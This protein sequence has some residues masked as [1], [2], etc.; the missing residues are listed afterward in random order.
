MTGT[1]STHKGHGRTEEL[2]FQHSLQYQ[3]IFHLVIFKL[4]A[5]QEFDKR[6]GVAV[7][8]SNRWKHEKWHRITKDRACL[9]KA[10]KFDKDKVESSLGNQ[11]EIQKWIAMI[12]ISD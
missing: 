7:D 12:R 4:K 9:K 11:G 10:K 5:E 8:I 6:P 1:R 2:I 3:E